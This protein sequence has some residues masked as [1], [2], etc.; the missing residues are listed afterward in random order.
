MLFM[1]YEAQT[2]EYHHNHCSLQP[3]KLWPM[4][5][6]HE[7]NCCGFI[8]NYRWKKSEACIT[9]FIPKCMYWF[10]LSVQNCTAYMYLFV[11]FEQSST[12]LMT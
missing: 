3:C 12:N 2:L 6:I 8:T 9:V 10:N 7:Y 5:S 11:I 1:P 4:K